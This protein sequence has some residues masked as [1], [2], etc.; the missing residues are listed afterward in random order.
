MGGHCNSVGLHLHLHVGEMLEARSPMGEGLG[1]GG[2][3]EGMRRK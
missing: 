2:R 1:G 3:E